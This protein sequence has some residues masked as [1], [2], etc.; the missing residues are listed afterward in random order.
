MELEGVVETLLSSAPK[1]WIVVIPK[2]GFGDPNYFR[3]NSRRFVLIRCSKLQEGGR[4]GYPQ[5]AVEA[6]MG[7]PA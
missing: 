3:I 7:L 6:V 5:E 2:Y 4:K 1:A